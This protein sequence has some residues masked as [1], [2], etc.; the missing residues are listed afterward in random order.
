[1]KYVG[2][3]DTNEPMQ[4]ERRAVEAAVSGEIGGLGGDV[5]LEDLFAEEWMREHTDAASIGAFV[6]ESDFDVTDQESFEEIPDEEWDD[7]VAG[8]SQFGSWREMLNAAIETYVRTRILDT[9]TRAGSFD[10]DGRRLDA[11]R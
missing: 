1:M 4:E 7:H 6:A 10:P 11:E 9:G 5:T 3:D 2:S 8:N